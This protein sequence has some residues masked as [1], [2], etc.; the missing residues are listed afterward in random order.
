MQSDQCARERGLKSEVEN[1]SWTKKAQVWSSALKQTKKLF[2]IY[3]CQ[4][5]PGMTGE[6]LL[7]G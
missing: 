1:A 4:V 2:L 5:V 7:G 3:G 6:F